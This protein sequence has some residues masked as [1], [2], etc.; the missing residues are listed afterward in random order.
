MA[1]STGREGAIQELMEHGKA[2]WNSLLPYCTHEFQKEE[3]TFRLISCRM[4]DGPLLP[5]VADSDVCR[6]GRSDPGIEAIRKA[7]PRLLLR[8][9]VSVCNKEGATLKSIRC[10]RYDGSV[11]H[12]FSGPWLDMRKGKA[13]SSPGAEGTIQRIWRARLLS[14]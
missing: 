12:S 5:L 9:E 10:G 6:K 13:R 4:Y 11:A 14:S 2:R 1:R 8:S 7:R 3:A